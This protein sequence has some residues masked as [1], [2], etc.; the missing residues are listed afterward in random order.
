MFNHTKLLQ[1]QLR[2]AITVVLNLIG[3]HIAK[4]NNAR[5]LWNPLFSINSFIQKKQN[6]TFCFTG[7][8][9]A[10]RKEDN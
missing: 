5:I 4:I 6:P 3:F 9:Y 2:F 7:R 1:L 8:S 10:A